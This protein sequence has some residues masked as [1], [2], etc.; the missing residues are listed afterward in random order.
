MNQSLWYFYKMYLRRDMVSRFNLL[1]IP[2]LAEVSY[3]KV[4]IKLADVNSLEDMNILNSVNYIEKLTGQKCLVKD[5]GNVQGK[6]GYSK[7]RN[8]ECMV[9]LRK[10]RMYN[11]LKY[12]TVSV[13]PVSI[14]RYGLPKL[15]TLGEGL[16]LLQLYDI[17]SFYKLKLN[18]YNKEIINIYF[19]VNGLKKQQKLLLKGLGLKFIE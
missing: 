9:T 16:Y 17:N 12:L 15:N 18:T 6:R 3:V 13:L 11:F 14:K 19:K 5:L 2:G 1:D 7:G 10:K 8:V 4:V